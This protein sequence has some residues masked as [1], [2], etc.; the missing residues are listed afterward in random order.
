MSG[1]KNIAGESF[2][3]VNK[4][5][6]NE[7]V[8]QIQSPNL[9]NHNLGKRDLSDSDLSS[10]NLSCTSFQGSNLSNSDL[11]NS[12]LTGCDFTESQIFGA[13]FDGSVLHGCKGLDSCFGSNT[14][15]SDFYKASWKGCDFSGVDLSWVEFS[16]R[17]ELESFFEGCKGIEAK[18]TVFKI[19]TSDELI[20]CWI[21]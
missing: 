1:R 2:F 17:E 15:K 12:N 11:S 16:S 18:Y 3:F 14:G 21:P 6:S 19:K 7:V 20:P 5:N 4:K 8:L 10:L 13:V 9:I